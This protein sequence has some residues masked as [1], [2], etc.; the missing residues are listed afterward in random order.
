VTTRRSLVRSWLRQD[1]VTLIEATVVLAVTAILVAMVAPVA[2]RSLDTARMTRAQ[3]DADSI[4]EAIGNF[5]SDFTGFTPF[6]TTGASGGSTVQM[7][8]G[9]GDIPQIGSGTSEWDDVVNPSA[10]APVDFLERHLVTNTP[11]GA[12]AYTTA[13]TAPWRGAYISGPID[14]DPWGDRY[15]V[16]VLYLRTSTSN[17]VFVLSAGPDRYVDTGFTLNGARP[18]DDDIMSV[19]RRD[20]GLT[21]P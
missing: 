20:V 14:P 6:T 2:S 5:L 9:D 11:G 16:N 12:G 15:A 18:Y 7:L 3:E 10:A 19:V 21:V 4:A 1:G 17:D 8:V 13:G